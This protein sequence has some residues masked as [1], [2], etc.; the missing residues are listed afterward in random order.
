MPEY[1]LFAHQETAYAKGREMDV[2]ALFCDMGTGK[3]LIDITD[4]EARKSF[5][6]LIVVRGDG[7]L[8]DNWKLEIKKFTGKDNVGILRG[9]VTQKR[10]IL[11]RLDLYDYVITNY[12]SLRSLYLEL[13]S[14]PFKKITFDESSQIKNPKAKCTHYASLL[15]SRIPVRRIL[16]GTPNPNTPLDLFSQFY[17]LNPQILKFTARPGAK[18]PV[19][20]AFFG[21]KHKYAEI[22]YQYHYGRK[23]EAVKVDKDTKRPVYKNLDELKR[24]IEPYCFTIKKKDCLDLPEELYMTR[25]VKMAEEQDRIYKELS[26][27]F[28]AEIPENQFISVSNCLA[29]MTRLQQI[30]GGNV[31]LDD[32]AGKRRIAE[33]KTSEVFNILEEVGDNKAVIWCRFIDEI[34]YL[35]EQ[36]TIAGYKV[37]TYY[38]D[39]DDKGA[40][41]NEILA[42][43]YDV[44]I[45]NPQSGGMGLNFT[46]ANYSIYYSRSFSFSEYMQSKDRIYR[47]GQ[48][49]KVTHIIL[50]TEGTLEES[51]NA[52]LDVKREFH[53]L[54]T[55]FDKSSLS[56]FLSGDIK[57]TS[58]NEL[59][60]A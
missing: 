43:N 49:K 52:A 34:V 53:E 20:N 23:H 19:S 8:K 17:C 40:V 2:F 39:T 46:T 1:K 31:V 35:R 42:G 11:S 29:K 25:K 5:P 41:Y 4:T 28:V 32:G 33:N 51:L 55:N 60:N 26:K 48:D 59:T 21:F 45:S 38:G 12:E 24:L 30:L 36:L 22:E 10:K 47:I 3:T 14:C 44:I 16:T 58:K 6:C 27:E 18:K 50:M 7:A 15:A 13:V 9:T 37:L 57:I 56:E 54:F